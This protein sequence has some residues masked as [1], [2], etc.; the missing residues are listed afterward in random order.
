MTTNSSLLLNRRIPGRLNTPSYNLGKNFTMPASSFQE[1]IKKLRN[2][3]AEIMDDVKATRRLDMPRQAI[4]CLLSSLS[5]NSE[6]INESYNEHGSKCGSGF[7]YGDDIASAAIKK[8]NLKF[9]EFRRRLQRLEFKI[10][11]DKG[12]KEGKEF[13]DEFDSVELD[14][15]IAFYELAKR[16]QANS[17]G[18][19]RGM[20]SQ[21]FASTSRGS[22]TNDTTRGGDMVYQTPAKSSL[23]GSGSESEHSN[24][25]SSNNSVSTTPPEMSKLVQHQKNS[26]TRRTINGSTVYVNMYDSSRTRSEQPDTGFLRIENGGSLRFG[27]QLHID[28]GNS[29]SR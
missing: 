9:T 12:I 21:M 16:V 28:W 23:E 24:E 13:E 15:L 22:G 17:K 27:R 1:E 2:N 5:S 25:E 29:P 4:A 10:G 26:W 19:G 8:A 3:F 18:D 7:A 6:T 20:K 14:V 11:R